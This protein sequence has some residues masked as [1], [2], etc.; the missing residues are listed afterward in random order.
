M[1][2]LGP[3][4]SCWNIVAEWERLWDAEEQ[5]GD[6]QNEQRLEEGTA[7]TPGPKVTRWG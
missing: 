5:G 3:L 4:I 7:G 6:A 1:S 2:K